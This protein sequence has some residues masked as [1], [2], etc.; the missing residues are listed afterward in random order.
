MVH[1][2][3]MIDIVRGYVQMGLAVLLASSVGLL[4][5][6]VS[7]ASF[8]AVVCKSVADERLLAVA[9]SNGS[10]DVLSGARGVPTLGMLTAILGYAVIL[11]MFAGFGTL[12]GIIVP[13]ATQW[14]PL[15]TVG[16]LL[17]LEYVV[18]RWWRHQPLPIDSEALH[19][20]PHLKKRLSQ[21]GRAILA[22]RRGS[23]NATRRLPPLEHRNADDDDRD[24]IGS[25][26]GDGHTAAAGLDPLGV[27]RGSRSNSEVLGLLEAAEQRAA[28]GAR[29]DGRF[30]ASGGVVGVARPDPP[31]HGT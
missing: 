25:Y 30:G 11:A 13:I 6:M 16:M 29:D 26:V 17:G 10:L 9:R 24:D 22:S 19:G 4:Y 21:F 8:A 5:P 2:R 23:F 18:R 27:A 1:R 12:G 15:A 14:L 20:T 7:A 31:G 3:F 28:A